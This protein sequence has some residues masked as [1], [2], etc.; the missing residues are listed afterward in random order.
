MI[1]FA[2]KKER[3]KASDYYCEEDCQQAP[4]CWLSLMVS[5]V[6]AALAM[7]ISIFTMKTV[8]VTVG[9]TCFDDLI[10]S[11]TSNEAVEVISV[12]RILAFILVVN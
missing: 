2:L 8:F 11:L 1:Q 5:Q 4:P 10:V 7:S 3:K 6:T 9:T 12:E